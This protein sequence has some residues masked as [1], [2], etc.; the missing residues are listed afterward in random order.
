M[1]N[2]NIVN[3]P[4][5]QKTTK[6]S[7][8][9]W[10]YV[11][12]SLAAGIVLA[13]AYFLISNSPKKEKTSALESQE[14]NAFEK[15]DSQDDGLPDEIYAYIGTVT[16][17]GENQLVINAPANGN[18]LLTDTELKVIVDEETE[19][20]N[21]IIPQTLEGVKPGVSGEWFKRQEIKF[22]QI[23]AGDRVTVIAGENIKHKTVF[24]AIKVEVNVIQ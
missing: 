4:A 1:D 24:K 14:K 7:L 10:P 16:A 12:I 19:L 21:L 9:P 23:K 22:D 2:I 13:S 8:G 11:F 17:V 3:N 20:A 5:G 15:T 6:K 18:Y